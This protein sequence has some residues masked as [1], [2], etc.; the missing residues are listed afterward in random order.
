MSAQSD[1]VG[2]SVLLS[3]FSSSGYNTVRSGTFALQIPSLVFHA[4]FVQLEHRFELL[5]YGWGGSVVDGILYRSASTRA[6]DAA[7]RG[8]DSVELVL[9]DFLRDVRRSSG[10]LE[11]NEISSANLVGIS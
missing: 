6:P 3:Y 8:G 10:R 9:R 5:N 2:H 4:L 11:E 7:L 1:D